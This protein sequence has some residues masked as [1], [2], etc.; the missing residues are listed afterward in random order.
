MTK[1]KTILGIVAAS[2]GIIIVVA[3]M[4]SIIFAEQPSESNTIEFIATVVDVEYVR[5][6]KSGSWQLTTVEYGELAVVDYAAIQDK[7]F[8]K[9]IK[10]QTVQFRIENDSLKKLENKQKTFIKTL[11]CEGRELITFDS[12]NAARRVQNIIGIVLISF[13]LATLV[14]VII[15]SVKSVRTSQE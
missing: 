11:S 10:N 8:F 4:L 9:S 6:G 13:L 1:K 2:V 3:M 14:G 15:I 12:Y 5:S 7:D